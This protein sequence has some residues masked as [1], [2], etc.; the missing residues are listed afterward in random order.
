MPAELRYLLDG[1]YVPGV[2]KLL[3]FYEREDSFIYV[4]ERFNHSMD[5]YDFISK[6][7]KLSEALA[8]DFYCQVFCSK[9]PPSYSPCLR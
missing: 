5:L 2:I 1:Q 9:P 4:M 6:E 3:E 7:K 8:R